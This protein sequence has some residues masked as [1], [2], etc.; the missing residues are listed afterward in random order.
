[1]PTSWLPRGGPTNAYEFLC[2][3]GWQSTSA[4]SVAFTSAYTYGSAGNAMTW[5]FQPKDSANLT[6]FY[7]YISAAAGIGST[8]GV[9][10]YEVRTGL[11]GS[12]KPGST[13]VASGTIPVDGSSGIFK[14]VSGLSI[15]LAG[16]QFYSLMIADADGGATNNVTAYAC[17][18][19]SQPQGIRYTNCL[20]TT[21]G[22]S[23]SGSNQNKPIFGA[24]KIGTEWIGGICHDTTSTIASSTLERGCR[25]KL[26]SAM[27]LVGFC[28]AFSDCSL[29]SGMQLSLYADATAPGGSSLATYTAP[30]FVGSGTAPSPFTT[31]VPSAS[32]YDCAAN[33]W[34]RFVAK[35]QSALTVPRKQTI[36][37]SIPADVKSCCFPVNG[38]CHHT[39]DNGSGGWTD[40]ANALNA[41]GPLFLPTD[42]VRGILSQRAWTGGI[43]A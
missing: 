18:S 14:H 32:Q 1:M 29:L 11:N 8:D 26:P 21:N 25:F 16:S 37:G 39:V 31:L 19:N 3:A 12:N 10:N 6:D 22:Y 4:T 40:D 43:P 24:I 36:S 2:L 34:Y 35:P 7:F 28:D 27:T 23:T 15:A 42:V 9:I 20:T 13:V 33:T 38:N 5:F 30:T 41:L 17:G